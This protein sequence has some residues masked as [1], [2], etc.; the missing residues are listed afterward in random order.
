MIAS[1]TNYATTCDTKEFPIELLDRLKAL[2][3]DVE[4]Q[5]AEGAVKVK[6]LTEQTLKS[7]SF[8][9]GQTIQ[10][11]NECGKIVNN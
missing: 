8:K 10:T 5:I 11:S 6:E 4:N 7:L 9:T 2:G 1:I 3:T